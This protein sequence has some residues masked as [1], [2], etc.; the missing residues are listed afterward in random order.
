[1]LMKKAPDGFE[2]KPFIKSVLTIAVPVALQN[3]L[4][5]TGSMIDTMMLASLGE[6]TVGA[7]GLCA[8]FS[9]LMF[10]CYWGF[11]GGGMLFFAQYWGAKDGRGI[12][13]SYGLTLSFM[14]FVSAVF[15]VLAT[16]APRL[17][18]SVYTDKTSIQDIGVNYL[19]IIGFEYP[20]MII[21]TAMSAL[22]RCTERV[23]IPLYGSACAVVT[24]VTLNWI[25][26]YGKLGFPAMGERGA[27]LAT[28]IA[29]GVNVA[30]IAILAAVNRHPY[31]FA[32]RQ[33]FK[34]DFT[35]MK[36]YLSRCFP[37]ICNELLIGVGTVV[38][39][40]VL[41]R[42]S[43]QA[44]AAT[45]VY[46]TL[47][48]FFICFFAGFTNAASILVGKEVGAG[49][50]DIAYSRAKRLVFLCVSTIFLAC[51]FLIAVHKPLLTAMSLHDE[52]YR[53]GTGML[54]IYCGFVLIRMCNWTMN[55]TYRS[56]GDAVYGTVL[57]ISF[58]YIMVLPAVLITGLWLKAPF[59]IVFTCTL[60][61]EPVRVGMMFRQLH[62]GR[63]V[64]P[65]TRE[66]VDALPAF[67]EK[68]KIPPDGGGRFAAI[69][70]DR[71]T[72]RKVR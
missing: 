66:G 18:M 58:M 19:K 37:I 7:V 12:N 72:A 34:I 44:I 33:H 1:M 61:D 46:R 67:R 8:Q 2:W 10:S 36:L 22:L 16:C 13:R 3:L 21:A 63:W 30:V 70:G 26:I 41:G 48:G 5:T 32:I 29:M 15:A 47:E 38:I 31:I 27:A 57:E 55:D 23:K 51:L 53:I 59:L 40:I 4:T 6:T 45:A 24:N 42:Q 14:L 20:L 50:H 9:S 49:N 28:V 56:A 69:F 43:E 54:F 17:V 39:N 68:H 11:V 64:R 35:M 60:I 25:L 62:S 65:V 52:S 71:R